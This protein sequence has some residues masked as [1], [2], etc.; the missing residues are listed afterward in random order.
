MVIQTKNGY[1][2]LTQRLPKKVLVRAVS[3]A[4]SGD[5][6][7][8][9]SPSHKEIVVSNLQAMTDLRGFVHEAGHAHFDHVVDPGINKDINDALILKRTFLSE[10]VNGQFPDATKGKERLD[11]KDLIASYAQVAQSEHFASAWGLAE[12]GKLLDLT[13][14]QIVATKNEYESNFET[15]DQLPLTAGSSSEAAENIPYETREAIVEHCKWLQGLI[16]ELQY[17]GLPFATE[18]V[19][20][21]NTPDGMVKITWKDGLL[22]IMA[23]AGN[24]LVLL[25]MFTFDSATIRA[26]IKG[27]PVDWQARLF[28]V[29]SVSKTGATLLNPDFKDA[30]SILESS[31]HELIDAK[32]NAALEKID[33]IHFQATAVGIEIENIDVMK[34]Y[35]N[36]M[37]MS[38]VERVV[39]TAMVGAEMENAFAIKAHNP[40]LRLA[41]TIRNLGNELANTYNVKD[42][43]SASFNTITGKPIITD[44]DKV[45]A[46]LDH[47]IE[48]Q[49]QNTEKA[50]QLEQLK[51]VI[52]A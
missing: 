21:V 2:D 36:L 51:K 30:I 39:W 31:A 1:Q 34:D 49:S 44:I 16:E 24:E 42:I 35:A 15:Y 6:D 22:S 3:L 32:E 52:L 50:L 46:V 38:D 12:L 28:D 9:F 23:D 37:K 41:Q 18:F 48:E 7:F 47:V 45:V 43:M 26:Y 25:G 13:P 29:Q 27:Q 10:H 33:S 20:S 5:R 19:Q 14:E 40:V 17:A 11:I 4:K 8:F